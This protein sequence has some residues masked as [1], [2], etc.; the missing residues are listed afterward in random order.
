MIARLVRARYAGKCRRRFANRNQRHTCS[1][2]DLA[3]HFA[4][5]PPIIR[6][7]YDAVLRKVRACGVLAA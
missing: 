4:D 6:T 2:L 5:K 7:L 1:K 3:H